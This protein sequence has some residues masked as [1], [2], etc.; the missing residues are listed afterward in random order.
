MFAL[1]LGVFFY[2]QTTKGPLFVHRTVSYA[3][4]FFCVIPLT[5]G[6][7]GNTVADEGGFIYGELGLVASE[8]HGA[9]SLHPFEQWRIILKVSSDS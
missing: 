4:V 1:I 6:C 9:R 2:M 8:V 7:W 3:L 5:P